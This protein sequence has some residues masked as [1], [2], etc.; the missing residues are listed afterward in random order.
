MENLQEKQREGEAGAQPIREQLHTHRGHPAPPLSLLL[1]PTSC[2]WA[3]RA[4]RLLAEHER[5]G[6]QARGKLRSVT[7]VSASQ[8]G[9]PA[10]REERSPLPEPGLVKRQELVQVEKFLERQQRG[11]KG[12]SSSSSSSS[13]GAHRTERQGTPGPSRALS[14]SH[15]KLLSQCQQSLSRCYARRTKAD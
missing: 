9:E 4:C 13:G 2:L 5:P 7:E 3:G 11:D 10:I 15:R 14:F 6:E 1:E 12:G 8:G